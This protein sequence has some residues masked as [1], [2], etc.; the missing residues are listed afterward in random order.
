MSK[1]KTTEG[2]SRREWKAIRNCLILRRKELLSRRGAD[3]DFRINQLS[4][5]L[6]KINDR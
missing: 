1:T 5:L 4:A 3:S 2:L 6:E